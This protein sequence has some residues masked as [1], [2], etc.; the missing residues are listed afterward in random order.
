[1]DGHTRQ[2]PRLTEGPFRYRT[3]ADSY[4]AAAKEYATR[5]IKQAVIAASAISLL[6]PA[7]GIEGYPRDEFNA[8]LIS[9]AAADIRRS[10]DAGAHIV[11]IDFTEGRLACKLDPSLG[12]LRSFVELN[13]RVLSHFSDEERARIGV[14]TCPGGDLDST[15]SADV[16][17]ALLLPDLLR[18]NVGTFYLQMASEPD[19]PRALR[20]IR[21]HARP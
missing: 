21:D 11:Q 18:L 15:H 2:L 3:F 17:Y 20:I 7:Q 10:L 9:Q 19:R 4:L 14:H 13:N 5:P 1:A 12:L 8:D 16:D 6:Y